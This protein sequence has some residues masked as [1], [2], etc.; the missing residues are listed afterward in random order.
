VGI[1]PQIVVNGSMHVL[2][3]DRAAIER[4]IAQTDRNAAVMSQPVLLSVSGGNLTTKIGQSS[5]DRTGGEVWL[6]A[7]EQAV[8][9]AIGRGEN[10]GRSV[11]YHNV[12]RRWLKLGDWNGTAST[13]SIP[14]TEFLTDGID[15]AVVLV[16]EGTRD[17]PGI[18]LGATLAPIT[19]KTTEVR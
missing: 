17:K 10:S 2:G 8:E 1:W 16:Q 3:S 5:K 12:V 4:M 13:F 9:V 11:T 6:C 18:I 19:R 7:L 15:A 14:T